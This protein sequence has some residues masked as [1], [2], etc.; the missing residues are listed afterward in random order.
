MKSL[1]ILSLA[2]GLALAQGII[3]FTKIPDCA[4]QCS[5]LQQADSNCVQPDVNIY[6]SCVCQSAFLT[7]LKTSGQPCEQFCPPQDAT[8]I[9]QYYISMCNAPPVAPVGQPT[10]T[11]ANAP[12]GAPQQTTTNTNTAATNTATSGAGTGV[13][14]DTSNDNYNWYVQHPFKHPLSP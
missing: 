6:Q 13:I 4:R 11:T 14:K 2:S 10:T 1:L 9:S 3:D 8:A 12:P 7:G 5:I